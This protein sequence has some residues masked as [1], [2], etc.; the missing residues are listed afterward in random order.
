MTGPDQI[1][2]YAE[3]AQRLLCKGASESAHAN[4][5]ATEDKDSAAPRCSG[6]VLHD[7]VDKPQKWSDRAQALC[8]SAD[9]GHEAAGHHQHPQ[10]VEKCARDGAAE[11]QVHGGLLLPDLQPVRECRQ[12]RQQARVSGPP[13][14]GSNAEGVRH[15]KDDPNVWINRAFKTKYPLEDW[16]IEK[17]LRIPH[18]DYG[19]LFE[20]RRNGEA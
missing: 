20:R 9:V 2:P 3:R 12:Q 4:Q 10:A 13:I 19:D 14:R 16:E 11:G 15:W 8:N 18:K 7:R 5:G 6:S 17:A 1:K